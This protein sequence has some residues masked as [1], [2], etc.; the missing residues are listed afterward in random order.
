MAGI[1]AQIS[2]LISGNLAGLLDDAAEPEKM[3]R[4]LRTEI[5]ESIIALQG[6][7]TRANRQH[8]RLEGQLAALE[9][10]AA[11]WPEK[12][13]VAISS[14]REDLA[15][16]ALQAGE[17]AQA[18]L[19]QARQELAD[20]A[21]QSAES[22]RAIGQLEAKL[23]EIRQQISRVAAE[24]VS[25]S[26]ASAQIPVER[27]LDR[28]DELERRL[29]FATANDSRLADAAND[30]KLD[31]LDQDSRIEAELAKLKAA[32]GEQAG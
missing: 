16:R 14:G 12:A 1:A 20:L 13:R 2:A 9:L 8:G 17:A 5:E 30:A 31:Q 19:A 28:I 11:E 15:R 27:R 4:L 32:I 6:D 21:A 26:Q 29:G 25:A 3:L 23:S 24:R 18:A 10:D 22:E 7:L